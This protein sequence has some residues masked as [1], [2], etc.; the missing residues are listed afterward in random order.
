M[1]REKATVPNRIGRVHSPLGDDVL[2]ITRMTAVERLSEPFSIVLDVVSTGA[3]VNLHPHL[4]KMFGIE[5][6]GEHAHASR[7]FHG[8]LWD[9]TE[10][11]AAQD[12]REY[13]YRLT[14]R[15]ALQA[16]TLNRVAMIHHKKSI[17]DLINTLGG[18]WKSTK[19]VGTYSAVEYRVQY[20][21]SDFDFLSRNLEQEGIYYYYEHS[22]EQHQIVF[23]DARNQH[24]AMVPEKVHLSSRPGDNAVELTSI[25]ER[26]G[27]A[28][29]K[30]SVDDYD[31]NAPTVDLK[32]EKKL[33]NLGGPPARYASSTADVSK[34]VAPWYEYPGKFDQPTAADGQR[35]A[36][37]ALERER[38]QM[39]R[40]FAEGNVFAAACGRTLTIAFSEPQRDVEYL[41]VGTTHRYSS[42]AYRSGS[43]G[44]ED[45]AV[46]LELMPHTLQ[47]RPAKRT[48]YPRVQGPQT[49]VVIGPS[50]EEIYTDKYGR[51][52]VKFFW[53]KTDTTAPEPRSAWVRVG[54]MSA[55]SGFG[56]FMVP[57]IGHEVIVEFLDG[58]PERPIITGSVYNASNLPAFGSAADN[59]IQGLKTNSSKGGGGY[60][61]IKLD[62]KKDSELFS[63]H[64]Q[65]D[66]KT[67]V[68]KGDE[69]RDLNEGSRTTVIHKG[70]ETMTVTKGKRTTTIEGNEDTTIKTGNV[71]HTVNTG[72]VTQTI[73]SGKRTTEIMGDD[74]LTLKTGNRTAEIKMGNDS[75]KVT[76]GNVDIKVSLG[77]HKTNAMQAID[78]V[79]GGSSIKMTPTSIEMKSLS[80]KIEGSLMFQTKGLMMQQE[81]SVMHIIK[82][83]IVMIN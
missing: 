61:E 73:K 1:G 44:D 8:M 80:V 45:M 43:G 36:E 24:S 31:Y 59:T 50:G 58:D 49:A 30:Y 10:L 25:V 83:G 81:A 32:K 20:Q 57:R 48:P 46:E 9:Y 52:K 64:A 74:S 12:Q 29:T 70:D 27:F 16:W 33:E 82:G 60:N 28:Q 62:D 34:V 35:F 14:L 23:I 5:F 19:L 75:L 71:T 18:N 55:G 67:V 47:Y 66:L 65:K 22:A 63:V 21:E 39:A 41:I 38:R 53:D 3:P 72:D 37:V 69:T 13:L 4:T 76:M 79:C 15:P 42:S 26:R 2:V 11:G 51:V 17:K 54:Q 7:W 68:D 6:K 78:L 77:S 56:A 40:S